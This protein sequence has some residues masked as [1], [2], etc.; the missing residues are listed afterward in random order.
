M[1]SDDSTVQHQLSNGCIGNGLLV[2]EPAHI[3]RTAMHRMHM[4][5][6]NNNIVLH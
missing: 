3:N 4:Q 5:L 2:F 6:I 1:Q